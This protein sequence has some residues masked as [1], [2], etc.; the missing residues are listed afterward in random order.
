MDNMQECP[1]GSDLSYAN[2]CAPLIT[3]GKRA[4]TAEALMRSRYTAY[5]VDAIEYLGETLHPSHRDD[6]DVAA[7]RRWAANSDWLRLEINSTEGGGEEDD[8]GVVEF[9][10]T[11]REKGVM[12]TH[13]E[14]SNFRRKDGQWYYVDGKIESPGTYVHPE[15]KVGRNDPCPCGSGKKHKKCCIS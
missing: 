1:C 9:S 4:V 8:S 12:H 7:T 13:H 14:F 3:G 15:P 2:C 5:V 11:F 6:H 10:A